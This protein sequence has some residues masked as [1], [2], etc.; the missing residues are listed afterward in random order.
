MWF[1]F[2][3]QER[4]IS[5]LLLELSPS[6]LNIKHSKR[7]G[8]RNSTILHV[9][10]LLRDNIKLEFMFEFASVYLCVFTQCVLTLCVCGFELSVLHVRCI[11]ARVFVHVLIGV[12]LCSLARGDGSQQ[13]PV[14]LASWFPVR[15]CNKWSL[16]GL[17]STQLAEW[18]FGSAKHSIM[19]LMLLPYPSQKR[20]H[21]LSHT[22]HSA[23]HH[24]PLLLIT[25]A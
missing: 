16:A 17:M 25:H 12:F 11:S 9:H 24:L 19:G 14:Y 8:G 15:A 6:H 21:T 2:N 13:F 5:G 3:V 1:L 18:V 23:T 7:S 22:M 20:T 10:Y 4:S